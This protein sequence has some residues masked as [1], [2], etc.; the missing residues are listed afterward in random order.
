[1]HLLGRPRSHRRLRSGIA[2][3]VV[4]SEQRG[5]GLQ[6]SKPTG[7]RTRVVP[8]W[9]HSA[10]QWCSHQ[11]QFLERRSAS[12]TPGIRRARRAGASLLERGTRGTL[13][14]PP[15]ELCRILQTQG[16]KPP[17]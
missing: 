8:R 13:P 4:A 17:S 12:N 7:R 15:R 11:G 2:F 5:L 9:G 3:R 1:M 10:G 16:R 6:N 14:H